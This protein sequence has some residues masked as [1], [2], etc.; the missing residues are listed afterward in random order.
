MFCLCLS[1]TNLFLFF[2]PHFIAAFNDDALVEV[3]A[4]PVVDPVQDPVVDL[5]AMNASLD[6][7]FGAVL[8]LP[9]QVFFLIIVLIYSTARGLP[10][11]GA[12]P[13]P[14]SE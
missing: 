1:L 10:S 14:Q 5:T 11:P 9:N 4:D 12:Q 13:H 8:S 3:S 7:L 2:F 6:G